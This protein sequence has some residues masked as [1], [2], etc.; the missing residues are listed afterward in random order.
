MIARS[1]AKEDPASEHYYW[2]IAAQKQTRFHRTRERLILLL[3][4]DAADRLLRGCARRAR[5]PRRVVLVAAALVWFAPTPLATVRAPIVV[6]AT[7]LALMV[8]SVFRQRHIK[9]AAS[10]LGGAGD[11]LLEDFTPGDVRRA[12]RRFR[13]SVP[14][15]ALSRHPR[16]ELLANHLGENDPETLEIASKLADEFAGTALELLEAARN[17]R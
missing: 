12:V 7:P 4:I 13:R 15:A 8:G 16:Q 14:A 5:S 10:L 2:K 11:D 9:K 1:L 17:L 6:F 3:G